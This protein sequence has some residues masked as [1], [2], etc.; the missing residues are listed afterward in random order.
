MTLSPSVLKALL[1]L[2][3]DKID[4]SGLKLHIGGIYIIA[5]KGTLAKGERS[6]PRYVK[7][8][9]TNGVYVLEQGVYVVRYAEYIRIPEGTIGLA[10]PRSSLLRMGATIH[11]AVWDSGY[12]GQ[13]IGLLVVFNPFGIVL[14]EEAHI[15]QLV[16]FKVE[17]K[18][19]VYKGIYQGEKE[20]L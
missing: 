14:E 9:S 4:T 2:H 11:T 6:I 3:D 13:G 20:Q 1:G 12:E 17:G 10:L 16:Y 19:S 15:A 18:P 7:L 8:K 5:D